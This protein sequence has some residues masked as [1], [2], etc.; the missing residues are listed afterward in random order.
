MKS[1][2]VEGNDLLTEKMF[3]TRGWFITVDPGKADL[4]C[5]TGGADVSPML[6]N[7]TKHKL[8]CNNLQRDEDCAEIF[9]NFLGTVPM[10]GICRGGQFLNVMCGGEM[11]QHVSGHNTSHDAYSPATGEV[12]KVTSTHHQMMVPDLDAPRSE[13]LLVA[14]CSTS[15]DVQDYLFDNEILEEDIEAVAYWDDWIVCFQPHPEYTNATTELTDYF[16]RLIDELM[17]EAEE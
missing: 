8:T 11:I 2:Y 5:F 1:V 7:S 4:I 14:D 13:L 16:F 9:Y 15:K 17:E 12:I 10:I 6:Y 3:A